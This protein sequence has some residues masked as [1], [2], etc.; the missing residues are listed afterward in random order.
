[1]RS[2]EPWVL[3]EFGNRGSYIAVDGFGLSTSMMRRSSNDLFAFSA[4]LG[5]LGSISR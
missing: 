3:R 5:G 4:V 2:G 1:V